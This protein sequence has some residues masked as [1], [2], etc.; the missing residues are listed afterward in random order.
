MDDTG[1]DKLSQ[2]YTMF[3]TGARDNCVDFD[4]AIAGH[5]WEHDLTQYRMRDTPLG[6]V[7]E[8]RWKQ[9]GKRSEKAHGAPWRGSHPAPQNRNPKPGR[10][11]PRNVYTPALPR[12]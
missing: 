12:R 2:A 5:R 9:G 1:T 6:R 11:A 4:T 8:T 10:P 3:D 7:P